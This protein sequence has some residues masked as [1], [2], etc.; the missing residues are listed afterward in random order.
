[1]KRTSV[2]LP[3]RVL[4]PIEVETDAGRA[5]LGGPKQRAVLAILVARLGSVVT[6]D[7]LIDGIWGEEPPTGVLSSLHTYVSNLRAAIGHP[8]ERY[9]SGYR[10]NAEQ[11]GVDAV[12][13]EDDAGA[14]RRELLTGPEAASERLRHALALWRGRAYAGLAI[15]PGLTNEAI[16]LE[17]LRLTAVE[18]RIEADL[19]LGRHAV[20][21]G[22]LEALAAEHPLRESLR[23]K[24]MLALYRDGR[25]ADALRV[26]RRT[27]E[28]LR[29]ELG[30]DPSPELQELEVRILNHDYSLVPGRDVVNERIVL[31]F[32]DIVDSARLGTADPGAMQSARAH[33]DEILRGAVDRAGGTVAKPIGDGLIAAFA[34][35]G[36]AARAAVAAQRTILAREWRPVDLGVAMAIDAGEVE[37]R[38][39]DLFGPPMNRGARLLAA[40]HGGQI[41]LSLDA[42]REL[43][44][45]P[46]TQVR[47]LGEHRFRGLASPQQLFQ[48]VADDLPDRFPPPRTSAPAVEINRGFGDVVRGYELREIVGRGAIASVYRAYQPAIGRE[49]AVKIVRPEFANHPSFVRRFESEARFVAALEHPHIATIHDFWR[50][51]DGAYLVT[52]FMAGG[53]LADHAAGP[54]N[55]EGVLR[56]AGDI[57]GAL[58]FAHRQGTL[59]R[60]LKPSNVLRDSD[61]NAYLADF[62]VAGRAAEAAGTVESA[63]AAYRAPEDRHG[64]AIDARVDVY[65]LAALV[66][67]LVT[68]HEPAVADVGVLDQPLSAALRRGL[69]TDPDE[70]PT[71]VDELLGHLAAATEQALPVRSEG[72]FRNPYKGLAAFNEPD[73]GD[74]FGRTDEIRRAVTMVAEHRL[75]AVVGPSG[76]GKSS[77]VLAGL[78]PALRAG[79]V[80]G[81]DRWVSV[82]SMPGG[83]PF[84]ELAA[85]LGRVATNAIA[86]LSG[87]LA[88]PGA[89]GLVRVA[90]RVGRE[91]DGE[92]LLVIDQ[93]E[94]LFTLVATGETRERFVASL[95][96]AAAHP[97]GRIR[98][99]LT[100]RADFFH[101][102]LSLP[103]LGPIIST[104]HL[105]LA[106]LDPEAIQEA[107]VAPARAAGLEFEP[108]LSDRIVADL[109]GQPGSLPLLE[110]T[111]DRLAAATPNGQITH[112]AYDTLGGVRG[113]IAERAEAAYHG[114]TDAQREVTRH[115]FTRLI[116]VSDDADD[117]RRRV[118]VSEFRSLGLKESDVQAVLDTFGRERLVTFD[119]DPT[120]R[121]ASVEVAHEALLREWPTLLGW[122]AARRES[123]VIQRRFQAA[124][125]EW[126]ESN[127]DPTNILSG[128]KL[129]QYEEWASGEDVRLTSTERE[130]LDTSIARRAAEAAERRTRRRRVLAGFAGAA[131]IAAA[132]AGIAIWQWGIAEAHARQETVRQLAASST[133]ALSEDP[134]RSI[135][136]A[137]EAAEVSISAG[138]P[139]RPEALAALQEAIHAS[140]L[141][142]RIDQYLA[143]GFDPD[144][145]L[146]TAELL[147]PVEADLAAPE[148]AVSPDGRLV[149]ERVLEEVRVGEATVAVGRIFVWVPDSREVISELAPRATDGRGMYIALPLHW[150]LDGQS[151]AARAQD[152]TT[153]TWSLVVWKVASGAELASIPIP[154]AESVAF[155]DSHTVAVPDNAHE[156]VR[157]F[158]IVSGD[159]VDHLDTPGYGPLSV[160]YDP[161]RRRLLLGSNLE[162]PVQA[163]D[164]ENDVAPRWSAVIG[165]GHVPTVHAEAGLVALAGFGGTIWLADIDDGSGRGVLLGHT[166]APLHIAPS[167]QGRMLASASLDETLV[168]DVSRAGPS[169][170][171]SIALGQHWGTAL[172]SPDGL[173]VA[174]SADAVNERQRFRLSTGQ[175][176]GKPIAGDDCAQ[177]ST[178]ATACTWPI[179]LSPDWRLAGTAIDGRGVVL[180]VNSGDI[181]LETP[182][183]TFPAAFGRNGTV[184]IDGWQLCPEKLSDRL[185]D[186]QSGAELLDLG[187]GGFGWFPDALFNPPGVF[188]A[189]RYLV[190]NRSTR[191]E[192]YDTIQSGLITS[193]NVWD[194]WRDVALSMAFDP[195]GQ[196][197]AIGGDVNRVWVIDMD[198]VAQ[199][200]PAAEAVIFD[201]PVDPGGIPELSINADGLLAT[202]GFGVLRLWDVHTGETIMRIPVKTDLPAPAVFT[203]E[204]DELLYMD[205]N[206]FGRVLRRFP[207]DPERLVEL[208]RSRL[209]REFTTEECVRYQLEC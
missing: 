70:R 102:V 112:H 93:L 158:D 147:H 80:P 16:R 141:E 58:S 86:D 156:R 129:S 75:S 163:W 196:L 152:V 124:H 176:I 168:W 14:A 180:D 83:H 34:E 50:D 21:I 103:V 66:A 28:Y 85:A 82:H 126:E 37:R 179:R 7:E 44:R 73:A 72:G 32:A 166:S 123:L 63:S 54:L 92:L 119:V 183:C 143:A 25:Q 151:V 53:S 39:G 2:A 169:S 43:G 78:L 190:L 139:V 157:V 90:E 198:L 185:I 130:L 120:T 64:G 76:S 95:A 116:T 122:V 149:A 134:E 177:T 110:F 118:R 117:L 145:E 10:L 155:L 87:E 97:A 5:Q 91:L 71:T 127:R 174:L 65:G 153:K 197:L 188:E 142:M 173:E 20:L 202:S 181:V 23:A 205:E 6:T 135:L 114:L 57:G 115:I 51:A 49:V 113:A 105:A 160:A 192:V 187:V 94:E 96:N 104:A 30:L 199:G 61:G 162:A 200:V 206:E 48:L 138:E 31:L 88:V 144:G 79:A 3:F 195:T 165:E 24:H 208:A 81:S 204:G 77:L 186:A 55:V 159:E 184:V 111:L 9:G 84:D 35:T 131:V 194:D 201:R 36:P 13:F 182:P 38:G 46:G 52:P 15:F 29:E 150:G 45:D 167:R 109:A 59:H 107:I 26:F 62:G 154:E 41:V 99:V 56:V 17:E 68:G 1:L 40:A 74:F 8:I 164:L 146:L 148:A 33:L 125:A 4:G 121:G 137:L 89:K 106:P 69:A 128:G 18:S 108:G 19:A 178:I 203:P 12:V 172:V 67:Y 133:T 136:L 132:F 11:S 170:L 171:G 101:E 193:L 140:R 22:E 98:I 175:P 189:D 100:L 209:T 27:Q 47:S 207:L 60:N 191:V 161:T 42:Q